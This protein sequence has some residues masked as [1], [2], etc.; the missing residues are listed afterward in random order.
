MN[1]REGSHCSDDAGETGN[2]GAPECRRGVPEKSSHRGKGGGKEREKP[3]GGQGRWASGLPIKP[4]RR[5]ATGS[6]A[7]ARRQ[8]LHSQQARVIMPAQGSLYNQGFPD[9]QVVL[10]L[11]VLPRAGCQNFPSPFRP[12]CLRK[13][14]LRRCEPSRWNRCFPETTKCCPNLLTL[15]NLWSMVSHP[16]RKVSQNRFAGC[17][18]DMY[19][20]GRFRPSGNW[21]R[22]FPVFRR[23]RLLHPRVHHDE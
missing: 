20:T 7:F 13:P 12:E 9:Y 21:T 19:G 8:C 6:R 18:P 22:R 4:I 10:P 15:G 23:L 17:E 1:P 11:G 2:A 14:T 16:S 3:T 5:P